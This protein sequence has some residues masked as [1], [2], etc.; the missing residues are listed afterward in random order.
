M[1]SSLSRT[2][3]KQP[4]HRVSILWFGEGDHQLVHLKTFTSCSYASCTKVSSL[5]NTGRQTSEDLRNY[6]NILILIFKSIIVQKIQS[7]YRDWNLNSCNTEIYFMEEIIN[8]LSSCLC[9]TVAMKIARTKPI[10]IVKPNAQLTDLGWPQI[11][12]VTK[13]IQLSL[14]NPV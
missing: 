9:I 11:I 6:E 10:S 1:K 8:D 5:F 7:W 13:L 4:A 2:L 14:I 12:Q 3:K